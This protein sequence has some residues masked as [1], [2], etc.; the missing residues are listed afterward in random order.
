[1]AK[2]SVRKPRR[3]KA[4]D[5]A[6]RRPM[7]VLDTNIPRGVVEGEFASEPFDLFARE[8]GTVHFADGTVVE[9]LAWF[10][11]DAGAWAKWKAARE[12]FDTFLDVREPIL[13]G[14]REI[15]A[16]A[17]LVLEAPAPLLPPAEQMKMNALI[18]SKMRRAEHL[19]DLEVA[20][21]SSGTNNLLL[22]QAAGAPAQV[23]TEA[24]EWGQIFDRYKA[25]AADIRLRDKVVQLD[26]INKSVKAIGEYIDARSN[27]CPP[28]SVRTDGMMR[29]HVLLSYRSVLHKNPYNP[30]KNKNATPS[31]INSSGILR[32]QQPSAPRTAGSRMIVSVHGSDRTIRGAVNHG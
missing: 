1:M 21:P 22:I 13:M 14:G 9:L 5:L 8:G 27:S 16:Q 19:K 17:G 20:F 28:A 31:T 11:R 30:T 6:K 26:T 12:R 2:R 10:H 4:F 29:V 23:K 15:L 7:L 25:A 3:S 18:W 24:A 32:F